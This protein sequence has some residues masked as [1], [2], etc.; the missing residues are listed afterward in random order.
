MRRVRCE[1]SPILLRAFV[2][3]VEGKG[4]SLLVPF[5]GRLH[6]QTALHACELFCEAEAPEEALPLVLIQFLHLAHVRGVEEQRSG[7]EGTVTV[8]GT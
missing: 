5:D 2:G 1:D 6:H 4:L 3:S 7:G 8:G